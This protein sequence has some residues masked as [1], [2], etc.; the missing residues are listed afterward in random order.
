V[1]IL[2]LSV[3]SPTR[4]QLAVKTVKVIG[5]STIRSKDIA[6]AREKAISDSLIAAVNMAALEIL[7]ADDLIDNFKKLDEILYDHTNRF[8]HAYRVLAEFRN[9]RIY[10][11]MLEVSVSSEKLERVKKRLSGGT[12]AAKEI[13]PPGKELSAG[14]EA[15]RDTKPLEILFLIS[16]QN[17]ADRSPRY[18]WGGASG[19][20]NAISENA[21]GDKMREKGFT[22]VS[23]GYLSADS[24]VKKT[25]T[26]QPD[27]DNQDAAKIGSRLKADVVI[28]GKSVVYKVEDARSFSGTVSARALWT[29]TGKEISSTLQTAV[30]KNV[31]EISGSRD[32]LI[33][34]GLLAGDKLSSQIAAASQKGSRADRKPKTYNFSKLLSSR[35][36]NP[37]DL[38]VSGTSDLGNFVKFRRTL[39]EIPGVK[40]IYIREKKFNEAIIGIDFMG[41]AG[42]FGDALKLKTFKLFAVKL[43]NISQNTLRAELIP[44]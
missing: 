6:K 40:R 7:S 13:K 4:G 29:D 26:Y 36:S 5:T 10:R 12:I 44:K 33:S 1:V 14:S 42:E 27:L 37:L 2:F 21:M 22:V 19:S 17:L 24:G 43:H 3:A 35:K 31:D 30:K 34:A 39:T 15:V 23:H 18:W 41:S 28:V 32:V 9:K 16:E 11:V 25:A 20:V 8:V 38:I